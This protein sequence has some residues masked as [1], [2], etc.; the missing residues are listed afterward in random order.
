[1][2]GGTAVAVAELGRAQK[3]A[4]LDVTVITT[5]VQPP[6]STAQSLRDAGV[7]V[8]EIG[9]AKGPL[10]R[11]ASIAP[12]LR[13]RI[14]TADIV[15]IAALWEEIQHQAARV[16]R[17]LRVP[18]L[19]SPHGML[20]PWSL[21]QSRLKKQ[22]YLAL[23]LRRDLNAAAA[24]HFTTSIERDLTTPLKLHPPAI[25]EP[26]GVDL[27]EFDDL[28]ARRTFRA[29]HPEIADK[30]MVLFLSRVH[31]KKGLDLL[32][33]AFAAAAPPQAMLVIAGPDCDGYAA[34]VRDAA[35]RAGIGQRV[36]FS[37]M[38]RG[39]DR[40]EPMVDADL[41]VLP[42]YQENFGIV[43]AEALAC[44]CPVI[45]SDQVN[46]H[47]DVYAAGVGQVVP[48]KIEPLG[49]ALKRWLVD[50]AQSR[51]AAAAKAPAFV[52]ERYDWNQ[53]A[54]RWVGHYQKL[55]RQ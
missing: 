27:R 30:P 8:V 22:I 3:R 52:R 7:D 51:Q 45:V 41:F 12:T 32:V 49:A 10:Q 35:Q 36:I 21:S 33:P 48:T 19:I 11:H 14:A 43:V 26:N 17:Q 34:Q 37:G 28:P 9:P 55:L 15:H 53:I 47:P 20:D 13:Q 4:G 23:R 25:V 18:Y 6:D 2:Q 29:K 24:L 44:G 39:R 16:A 40:L 42:S 5:F 50:D 31:P 54:Q 1:M 38:L 46:I